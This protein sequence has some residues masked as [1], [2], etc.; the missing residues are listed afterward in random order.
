VSALLALPV[1]LGLLQR[2]ELSFPVGPIAVPAWVPFL[3]FG[4]LQLRWILPRQ[5]QDDDGE[6]RQRL[7]ASSWWW[8]LVFG[9]SWALLTWGRALI[10]AWQ[11]QGS[12]G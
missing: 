7:L 5:R 9:A 11:R 1:V 3:V 6:P 4:A 12:G 8:G 10:E 2:R